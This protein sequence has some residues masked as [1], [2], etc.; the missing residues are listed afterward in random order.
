LGA[1]TTIGPKK[2]LVRQRR[3]WLIVAA[4]LILVGSAGSVL[5][6]GAIAREDRRQADRNATNSATEVSVA[7]IRNIGHEQDL[8]DVAGAFVNGDPRFS[9]ADFIGWGDAA[10][11]FERYPELDGLGVI[12]YVP[13]GD[14]ARD[15]REAAGP[16]RSRRPASARSTACPRC[17]WSARDIRR[18]RPDTT[19]V[20]VRCAPACSGPGTP[21]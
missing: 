16:I 2:T 12:L 9:Q 10:Q 21:G 1:P 11:I 15:R 7:L 18:L 17:R 20:R 3:R 6:S 14:L 13:A 4:L 8:V 5:S 19:S